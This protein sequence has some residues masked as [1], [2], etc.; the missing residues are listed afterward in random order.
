MTMAETLAVTYRQ[1]FEILDSDLAGLYGD[2]GGD[3]DGNAWLPSEPVS[4]DEAQAVISAGYGYMTH[5]GYWTDNELAELLDINEILAEARD[6]NYWPSFQDAVEDRTNAWAHFGAY[7]TID[8]RW[9][10]IRKEPTMRTYTVKMRPVEDAEPGGLQSLF[11]IDRDV[12]IELVET[13]TDFDGTVLSEEW[14][15]K[16]RRDIDRLLDTSDP[17]ISYMCKEETNP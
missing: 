10:I 1:A 2:N 13:K 5:A 15:V 12:Q 14:E 3:S 9:V 4:C 11:A 16:T 7:G 6:C 8:S 17:V